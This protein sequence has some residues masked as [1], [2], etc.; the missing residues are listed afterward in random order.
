MRHVGAARAEL[1]I[2]TIFNLLGPLANPAGVQHYLLG[3]F[4]RHWV[5]PIAEALLQ[6]GARHA[7]VVHGSDGLDEITTTGATA[8]TEVRDGQLRSFEIVPEDVGLARARPEDLRGGDSEHNAEALRGVLHGRPS[9]YRDIAV[10]NAAAALV[11]AGH[12]PDLRGGVE[13]AARAIDEGEA[14]ARLERL[15]AVSN[16]VAAA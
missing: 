3:V 4:A 14:L 5:E 12:V 2:R 16:R 8:I 10:L 9:P 7:W 15:I 13:A 11:A 6:L 1:G